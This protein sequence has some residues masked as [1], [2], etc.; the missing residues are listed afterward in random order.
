MVSKSRVLGED[1]EIA[2]LFQAWT[3][4]MKRG[5]FSPRLNTFLDQLKETF[6]SSSC[7]G[8]SG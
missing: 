5:T 7:Q 1:R 4:L 2:L 8:Q 6:D 3:G